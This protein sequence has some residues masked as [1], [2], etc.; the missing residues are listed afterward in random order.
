MYPLPET[1]AA[2]DPFE[3][4]LQPGQITVLRKGLL[5]LPETGSPTTDR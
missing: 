3:I 5:W 2:C 4:G 1:A